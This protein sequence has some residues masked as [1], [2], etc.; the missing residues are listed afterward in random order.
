MNAFL[1]VSFC[2][3]MSWKRLPAPVNTFLARHFL[4]LDALEVAAPE[5]TFLRVTFCAR[6]H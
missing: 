2:A 6:T 4:R 3:R 5:N 1:C